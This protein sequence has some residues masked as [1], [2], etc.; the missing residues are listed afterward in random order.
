MQ[1]NEDLFQYKRVSQTHPIVIGDKQIHI[2]SRVK[3]LGVKVLSDLK[4]NHHI[5]EIV[6]KA[7]KWLFC[8]SH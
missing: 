8:L 6:K 3:I 2:V 1:G 5:T 4:R 7:R